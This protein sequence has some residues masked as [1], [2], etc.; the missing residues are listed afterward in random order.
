[1]VYNQNFDPYQIIDKV[2]LVIAISVHIF[3]PALLILDLFRLCPPPS[4]VG[5]FYL[6]TPD[7]RAIFLYNDLLC[8]GTCSV[9]GGGGAHNVLVGGGSTNGKDP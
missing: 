3:L 1:M 2:Q 6:H 7:A 4:L 9:T 8:N 5:A